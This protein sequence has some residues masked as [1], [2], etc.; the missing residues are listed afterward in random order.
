MANQAKSVRSS[1]SAVHRA[2]RS[3]HSFGN[4]ILRAILLAFAGG[5]GL[6]LLL[7]ALLALLLADTALPLTLVRPFACTASAAGSAFSGFLLA[8]KLARQYLLCG[9]GAG[10]FFALCQIIAAFLS[11]GVFLWQGSDFM[12]PI[13]LILGGLSGG[14]LAALRAVR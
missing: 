11:C 10:V 4:T 7:L 14:A 8:R 3:N 12:L 2:A 13:A 5:V 9:L 6:C 1:R